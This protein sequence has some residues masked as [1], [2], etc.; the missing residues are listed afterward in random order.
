[1]S[2]PYS[3]FWSPIVFGTYTDSFVLRRNSCFPIG[4]PTPEDITF[5]QKYI[6]KRL[7]P[8]D[9][10]RCLRIIDGKPPKG[11]PRSR[12]KI[13]K[14]TLKSE[15]R[16]RLVSTFNEAALLK[17]VQGCIRMLKSQKAGGVADVSM[18][19]SSHTSTIS[20]TNFLFTRFTVNCS[21]TLHGSCFKFRQ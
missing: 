3:V 5:F 13:M 15:R 11:P 7:K 21:P 2:I 18:G 10:Q 19:E 4:S 9:L 1:M 17:N 8:G 12:S 16:E 6:A 20:V 14:G